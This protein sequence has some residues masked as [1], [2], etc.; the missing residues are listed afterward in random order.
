MANRHRK[1]GPF[2]RDQR[3]ANPD[4]RTHAGRILKAVTLELMG[5]LGDA[6]PPQRLL[7]QSAALKAVRLSLL[8][9]RLLTDEGD[10][11]SGNDH[12]CLAW[13]NSL[14]LDLVALG[15][16][17]RERQILDLRAYTKDMADAA[18]SVTDVA[19]ATA[20]A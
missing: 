19:E 7:V 4:R 10:L 13:L 3:L 17:R 12:H 18:P 6:T 16:E 1:I 5:H 2:S 9:Q 14:R 11:A 8:T 15:L 20:P